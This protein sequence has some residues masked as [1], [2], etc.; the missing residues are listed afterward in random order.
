MNLIFITI[1]FFPIPTTLFAGDGDSFIHK[2]SEHRLHG[3]DAPEYKQICN[4]GWEGGVEAIQYLDELKGKGPLR[5]T[6]HHYDKY[7]RSIA[8][9]YVGDLNLNREILNHV[10]SH[11]Y[12][13]PIFPMIL[14]ALLKSWW[15]ARHNIDHAYFLSTHSIY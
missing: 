10:T 6:H 12:R 13:S 3:I 9:C 5:C 15:I 14:P 1:L 7:N 4:A 8:T 11:A 2:G